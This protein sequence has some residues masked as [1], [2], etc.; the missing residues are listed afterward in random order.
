MSK[1]PNL[2]T[3]LKVR[4]LQY[5]L[6]QYEAFQSA[7]LPGKGV[8]HPKKGREHTYR[9]L[10]DEHLSCQTWYVPPC[11]PVSPDDTWASRSMYLKSRLKSRMYA[12]LSNTLTPATS[13]QPSNAYDLGTVGVYRTARTVRIVHNYWSLQS[14]H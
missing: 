7:Y 5:L 12:A 14:S 6:R 4:D 2:Y 11:E 9:E 3:L 1:E 13:V 8:G 10:K